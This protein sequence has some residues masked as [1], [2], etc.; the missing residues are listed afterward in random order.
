MKHVVAAELVGNVA[1][2]QVDVGDTVT[3]TH[4]VVIIES[5]KMEIPVLAEVHGTVVEIAVSAG[6]VISEGDVIAV[7]DTGDT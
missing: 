7:I 4:T 3:A 6:D 2:V 5:M 1:E